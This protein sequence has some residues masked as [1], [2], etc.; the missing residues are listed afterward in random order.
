MGVQSLNEKVKKY[1]RYEI[2][3][4]EK[5]ELLEN[6]FKRKVDEQV[7]LNEA[8]LDKLKEQLYKKEKET[9]HI[10]LKFEGLKEKARTSR[11]EE[12]RLED[13][14]NQVNEKVKKYRKYE[15]DN[16]EKVELLENKFKRKVDEQV[17]LNEGKLD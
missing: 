6:K 16:K 10:K 8:K 3:N 14:E 1:R 17:K 4:K 11:Q 13:L 15:N 2:D 9:E 5:V 7:K 12:L